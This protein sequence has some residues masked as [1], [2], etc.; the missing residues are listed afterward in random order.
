MVLFTIEIC[1]LPMDYID[2]LLL[3]CQLPM[4]DLS[5]FYKGKDSL[6][7]VHGGSQA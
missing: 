5:K 2:L 7:S 3:L 1:N 6:G 4:E